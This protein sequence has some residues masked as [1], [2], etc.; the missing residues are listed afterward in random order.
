MSGAYVG[1]DGTSQEPRD[2][3]T[4]SAALLWRDRPG[5]VVRLS[6]ECESGANLAGTWVCG[7][8]L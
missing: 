2:G 6:L 4:R 8:M 7:Y 1:L 5:E 3:R